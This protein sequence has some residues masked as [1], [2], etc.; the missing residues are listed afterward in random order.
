M[1]MTASRLLFGLCGLAVTVVGIFMLLDRL[2]RKLPAGDDPN[3]I[4][5]L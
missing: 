2:R 3:I 1:P 4:D 5:A